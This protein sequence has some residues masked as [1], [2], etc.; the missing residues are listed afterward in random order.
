MN[1]QSI[2]VNIYIEHAYCECGEQME[3]DNLI[4]MSNPP[5]YKYRC[6]KCGKIETSYELYPKTFYKER[7]EHIC[8]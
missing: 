6:P 3:R 7:E 8:I 1:I 4:L 5:R 2:P